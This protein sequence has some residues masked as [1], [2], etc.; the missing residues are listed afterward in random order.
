M[1]SL[2]LLSSIPAVGIART[3]LPERTRFVMVRGVYVRVCVRCVGDV[4]MFCVRVCDHSWYERGW[5]GGV[6]GEGASKYNVSSD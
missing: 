4:R 3:S 5:E 1:R 2:W 6:G